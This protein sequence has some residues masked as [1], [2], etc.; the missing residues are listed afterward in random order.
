MNRLP[1]RTNAVR[2]YISLSL[3]LSILLCLAGAAFGLANPVMPPEGAPTGSLW[4]VPKAKADADFTITLLDGG[5]VREISMREYLIGSVAAEMPAS[6]ERE[7]L[8]AQAVALRTYALRKMLDGA[9]HEADIC[10]DPGCCAAWLGEA[11]LRERWGEGFDKYSAV[12]EDAVDSTDGLFLSYDSAPA[13]AVFHAASPGRTESGGAVWGESLPYLVS[14]PSPESADTVPNYSSAVTLTPEELATALGDPG[15]TG[16]PEK[17]VTDAAWSGSGRLKTVKIGGREY[18]GLRLRSL[19]GLR[20]AAI[21]LTF[22]GEAFRITAEGS[23]HG[24]GMSQYGANEKAKRG[25]R[26]NEILEEYYP[27]TELMKNWK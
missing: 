3:S 20:S 27:G 7:A 12:I 21:T 15:L 8:R 25:E 5:E 24:V 26:F 22:D 17:W 23:G 10:S 13:L 6:F 19:L 18:T 4:Y 11:E 14:V 9:P 1:E 16:D 2:R